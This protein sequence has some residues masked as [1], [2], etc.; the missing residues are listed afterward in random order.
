MIDVT[1]IGIE[2]GKVSGI[3]E[4]CIMI[5]PLHIEVVNCQRLISSY[6]VCGIDIQ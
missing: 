1:D 4:I 6:T 3:G 5:Q 2:N